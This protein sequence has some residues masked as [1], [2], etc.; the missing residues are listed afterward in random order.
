MLWGAVAGTIPDLDILTNFFMSEI[1]ATI[2][3]RHITHAIVFPF[4][5]APLFGWLVY[6]FY[7]GD[8]DKNPI[9]KGT[10][11]AIGALLAAG[12]LFLLALGIYQNGLSPIPLT[13]GLALVGLIALRIRNYWKTDFSRLGTTATKKE[14]SWLFFW[15]LFTHPLLDCFT[16]YGTQIFQPFSDYRV[17]FSTVAV[18]D[19]FYTIPFLTC[20]IIAGYLTRNTKKRAIINWIG[21]VFSCLYLLLTIR[22]KMV[23]TKIFE[24]NLAQHNIKYNRTFVSPTILNNILWQGVAESKYKFYYGNYSLLD[25][26]PVIKIDSLYKHHNRRAT[27]SQYKNYNTLRWFSNNYFT[28]DSVAPN[29]YKMNDLRFGIIGN[30]KTPRDTSRFVFQFYLTENDQNGLDMETFRNT[31]RGSSDITN[32]WNRIKGN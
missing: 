18:A 1:N 26:K 27:L 19:P 23:V 2:A 21:I 20:V 13:I 29:K 32:L 17:A 31:E 25:N 16:S 30:L 15:G 12:I 3:H 6:K 11:S 7:K 22:N 5:M 9:Y 28:L 14:W 10:I 8:F 24:D 4:F